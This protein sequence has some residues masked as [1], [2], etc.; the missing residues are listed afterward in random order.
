MPHLLVSE[1]DALRPDG[2]RRIWVCKSLKTVVDEVRSD[3][4]FIEWLTEQKIEHQALFGN[5]AFPQASVYDMVVLRVEPFVVCQIK[6]SEH[7]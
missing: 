1:F 4:L 3:T 5:V 7:P 6:M 2:I